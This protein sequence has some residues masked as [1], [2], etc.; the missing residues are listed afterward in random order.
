[1][2]KSYCRDSSETGALSLSVSL[3]ESLKLSN[4]QLRHPHCFLPGMT[5]CQSVSLLSS[6]GHFKKNE[7][8]FREMDSHFRV[9]CILRSVEF[10]SS[11]RS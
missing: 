5:P 10:H 8:M 6:S 4:E 9:F 7:E 11:S 2:I 3:S 1:M